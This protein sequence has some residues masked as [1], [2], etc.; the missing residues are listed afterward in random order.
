[1]NRTDETIF[2]AVL[3]VSQ[4]LSLGAAILFYALGGGIGAYLGEII[5]WPLYWIGQGMVILLLLSGFFLREYFD[6][7]GLPFEISNPRDSKQKQTGRV[8]R[9]TFLQVALTTLT[10][11]AV[12]TVIVMAREGFSSIIFLFVGL[13][14]L[15]MI[16]Y[17]LPPFRLANA[18][19]GELILAVM[20]AN[21]FPALA[22]T[23]Q[24]GEVHRLLAMLTFPLT[25]LYLASSLALSL[26]SYLDDMN[27][28]RR[29][30]LLRLGWQ[31]GMGLHNLLIAGAYVLL[32]FSVIAGLPWRLGSPG[33]LALPISV[34]QIWQIN[35]IAAGQKPR[36]RLLLITAVAA[37]GLAV[38]FMNLTLWID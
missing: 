8:T 36:W 24:S 11:G 4:P 6:R 27:N 10:A 32:A 25:F 7:P 33:F 37:V 22:F 13:A 35:Q 21:L 26:R 14:F 2:A 19:Y 17:A 9:V 28:N 12:L 16:L 5:D 30:M 29:T 1:M 15:L 31:R 34:Y 23:F 20:Q 18:G 38:Y 3:K